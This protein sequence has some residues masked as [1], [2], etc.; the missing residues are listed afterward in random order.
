M[1]RIW[2]EKT[3]RS[4]EIPPRTPGRMAPGIGEFEVEAEQ[5][6]HE[7]DVGQIGVGDGQKEPLPEGHGHVDDGFAL[8]GEGRLS[9]SKRLRVFPSRASMISPSL[10]ATRSIS[11]PF[12]AS[13][14]V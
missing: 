3:A 6:D 12:R 13:S 10:F 8:E 2:N 9:P 7:Q 5:A 4:R 1:G 11:P 14:S